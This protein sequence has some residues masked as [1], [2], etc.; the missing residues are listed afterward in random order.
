MSLDA[1][2]AQQ[3]EKKGPEE[4]LVV[5]F[6]LF[7]HRRCDSRAEAENL[8]LDIPKGSVGRDLSMMS[9]H[10]FLGFAGF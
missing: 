7:K 3:H 10:C 8:S 2:A 4:G 5:F 6:A 1:S 9:G